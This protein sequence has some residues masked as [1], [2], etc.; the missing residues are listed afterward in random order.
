M[1]R[2]FMPFCTSTRQRVDE[3]VIAFAA[4]SRAAAGY[5]Q[6]NFLPAHRS[7]LS[8][9][10]IPVPQAPRISRTGAPEV[11]PMVVRRSL[12]RRCF[13]LAPVLAMLSSQVG[14]AGILSKAL[15]SVSN[16]GQRYYDRSGNPALKSI[17]RNWATA[18]DT[19]DTTRT[20]RSKHKQRRT[21]AASMVVLDRRQQHGGQRYSGG[22]TLYAASTNGTLYAID[23]ATGTQRW[24]C[25]GVRIRE[26]WERASVR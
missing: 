14:S 13:M 23:A 15:V 4:A 22:K 7:S 25:D 5:Q 18:P 3:R 9:S 2:T 1:Y 6:E 17:G 8:P 10:G 21:T 16:T 12:V 11:F 24:T 20:R 26:Q 19:R